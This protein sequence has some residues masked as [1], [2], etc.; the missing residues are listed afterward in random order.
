MRSK[1][2]KKF[3]LISSVAIMILLAM[4]TFILLDTSAPVAQAAAGDMYVA[5]YVGDNGSLPGDAHLTKEEIAAKYNKSTLSVLTINSGQM[6]YD[7]L[8]GNYANYSVGYLE[9]NV[10][11]SYNSVKEGYYNT[12][13]NSS[14]A[15][16]DRIFDGNGYTLNLYGGVGDANSNV[17]ISDNDARRKSRRNNL[18]GYGPIEVWYEYT[19][20]LLSLIHI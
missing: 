17:E 13:V 9:S 19:G 15:I 5:E 18:D 10:G 11:I 14:N 4:M 12:N 8:N 7:F 6:L 2:Q 20:F 1:T 3:I 16:F